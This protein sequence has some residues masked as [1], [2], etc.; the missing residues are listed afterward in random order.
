MS[1]TRHIDGSVFMAGSNRKADLERRLEQSRRLSKDA[2]DPTTKER[3]DQ[4]TGD[5]EA[6]QKQQIEDDEK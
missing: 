1:A 6:E 5:L 2:N 3:L 4:L